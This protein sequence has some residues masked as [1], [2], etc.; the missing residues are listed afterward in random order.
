MML[1]V[2]MA[3]ICLVWALESQRRYADLEADAREIVR[4]KPDFWSGAS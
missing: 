3:H 4:L 2:I 1:S